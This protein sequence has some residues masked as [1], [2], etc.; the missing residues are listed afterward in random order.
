MWC[1]VFFFFFSSRRRHTRCALVTGVQTCAL[2]ICPDGGGD[3]VK[4]EQ[5]ESGAF[6]QGCTGAPRERHSRHTKADRV[7]GGVSEEVERVCLQRLGSRRY[8]RTH[9]S[10]EH[11]GVDAK[12]DPQRTAP[13]GIAFAD[14]QLLT[15]TTM[16][17]PRT[18]KSVVKGKSV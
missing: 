11:E 14:V 9:L 3:D 16:T 15:S 7:I 13:A 2:P 6:E 18:R 4:A 1:I 8:A 12:R 17:G 10:D 5:G